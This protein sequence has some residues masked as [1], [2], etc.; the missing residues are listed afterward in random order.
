VHFV[1]RLMRISKVRYNY[2]SI[3][4]ETGKKYKIEAWCPHLD[5]LHGWLVKSSRPLDSIAIWRAQAEGKQSLWLGTRRAHRFCSLC[6]QEKEMAAVLAYCS[7]AKEVW[8]CMRQWANGSVKATCA[9][10]V[11]EGWWKESL[12]NR[13]QRYRE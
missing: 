13:L 1:M 10:V 9:N 8:A 12:C 3:S 6:D 4:A 2:N 11:I 5:N 7:F